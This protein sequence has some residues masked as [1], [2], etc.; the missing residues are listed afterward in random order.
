MAST[1]PWE[2]AESSAAPD[3]TTIQQETHPSSRA[4]NEAA[5]AIEKV[6]QLD[7]AK[8]S[9]KGRT[10]LVELTRT[11]NPD[12]GR[13]EQSRKGVERSFVDQRRL[14]AFQAWRKGAFVNAGIDLAAE[15]TSDE[16]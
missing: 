2:P 1:A 4:L 15:E 8:D 16:S 9:E 6:G 12:P 13:F 7:I 14:D 5:F 11:K 3:P 10:Y